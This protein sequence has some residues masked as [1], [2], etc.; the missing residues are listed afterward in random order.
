RE[1]PFTL[2]PPSS[3]TGRSRP[4]RFFLLLGHG[5]YLCFVPRSSKKN[6]S[7]QARRRARAGVFVVRRHHPLVRCSHWL[8][9]VTSLLN[10]SR[11]VCKG[12]FRGGSNAPLR[13]RNLKEKVQSALLL[14]GNTVIPNRRASLASHLDSSDHRRTRRKRFSSPCFG[15]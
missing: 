14:R 9:V 5:E 7:L 15:V 12:H 13:Q 8:S 3:P 10:T 11:Q 4:T 2:R 1:T 6:Q